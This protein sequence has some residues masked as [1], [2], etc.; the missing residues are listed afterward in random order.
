MEKLKIS[1][2]N[3]VEIIAV[4]DE[5]NKIFVPVKPICEAIGIRFETQY[6]KIQEHF[7]LSPA[8]TIK[9]TTGADGKTREMVCLPF[10][11][12]HGWLVTI[13]PKNVSEGAREKVAEYLEQ[14]YKVLGN[15]F[16]A[17]LQE[18]EEYDRK[19][20][21]LVDK[22]NECK[23]HDKECKDRQKESRSALIKAE[24]ELQKH[25]DSRLKDIH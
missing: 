8:L 7:L 23:A 6:A 5:N 15:F 3:G 16:E 11:Q 10:T 19:E 2:I 12:T 13:N 9:E 4:K 17:P 20:K 1:I 18:R 24:A 25:R 22:V 21:E 14:C